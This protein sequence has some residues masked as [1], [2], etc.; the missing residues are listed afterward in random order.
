MAIQKDIV[1]DSGIVLSYWRIVEIN[2]NQQEKIAKIT[3]Y[4]YA[5]TY[6]RV[7]GKPPVYSEMIN[8]KV[9]DFDYSESD[10]EEMTNLDYT[11]NFAPEALSKYD[12]IYACAYNYLK[13]LPKFD[14][15]I[16]V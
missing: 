12:N 14:G 13:G 11:N 8:I 3:V 2:V 9:E 4:P 5:S 6:A 1:T 15:A 10:Y 16:D 7:S